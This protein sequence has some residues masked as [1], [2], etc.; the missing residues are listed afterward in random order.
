[1][2]PLKTPLITGSRE[3]EL[4]LAQ[5][6]Y[7]MEALK[8]RFPELQIGLKT[9]KTQGDR[10]LNVPLSGVGDK[11]LFVKELEQ[12]LLGG[13][14]DF[15][16]HSMKDMPST[17]PEGLYLL[18]FGEREVALDA[19]I[20]AT[21]ASFR[22]LPAGSVIGTSSLR[23]EAVLRSLR[24]ELAFKLLR[25]NVLTRLKKLDEGAYDAIV[26]AAAGLKRLGLDHRITHLFS[27]EEV[28]PACSQ[29][30]LGVEFADVDLLEYFDRFIHPETAAC[31][32]AERALQKAIEGGCQLP[33]GGYA[34]MIPEEGQYQLIG[35][36]ADLQG[37][38]V[39]RSERYFLPEEAVQAGE[40][41]GLEILERGGREILEIVRQEKGE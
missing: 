17:Q 11:G 29:G 37:R 23:R 1:M 19:F 21:G 22:E 38:R 32:A 16:V 10:M 8:T 14:I 40:A 36:V 12:A 3:S 41:V 13:D 39:I 26:L 20:S 5:T 15:A 6:R 35:M 18:P 33:M 30:V 4:A 7:V 25:G 27:P 31:I 24:P 2:I 9:F 28:L 34:R